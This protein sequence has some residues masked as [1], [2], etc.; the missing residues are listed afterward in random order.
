MI[1]NKPSVTPELLERFKAYHRDNGAWGSLHI[2]LD[3]NNLKDSNVRFCVK[4]ANEEGDS[5]GEA[6]A[7]ILLTMSKTQRGKIARLA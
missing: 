5:E 3:D 2:V 4:F 7:E 6:L 1:A